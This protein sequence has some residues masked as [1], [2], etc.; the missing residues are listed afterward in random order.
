MDPLI[1]LL[2]RDH[3]V[4][5]S[6]DVRYDPR[7]ALDY[8]DPT[9]VQ[10]VAG[11]ATDELYG[12][13]D[14]YESLLEARE[15]YGKGA[16]YARVRLL[17]NPFEAISGA[18]FLNRAAT[19]IASI[20][21][22]FPS[23]I[24]DAPIVRIGMLAEAPGAMLEYLMWHVAQRGLTSEVTAISLE[25]GLKWA[26]GSSSLPGVDP[27]RL[28]I[29]RGADGTGDL[30][31][32]E[33]IDAYV[34]STL[35][36]GQRDLVVADGGVDVDEHPERQE[37][38]NAPLILGETLC[39]LQVLRVGGGLVLKIYDGYDRFTSDAL[40]LLCRHFRRSTIF[41]PLTSRPANAERY[42]VGL[43]FTG[44]HIEP[45]ALKD[46]YGVLTLAA[47]PREG[48]APGSFLAKAPSI[49]SDFIVRLNDWHGRRQV[50][51]LRWA[52]AVDRALTE[53]PLARPSYPIGYDLARFYELVGIPY[54]RSRVPL[55]L[56]ST[57]CHEIRLLD[58]VGQLARRVS[59]EDDALLD[60]LFDWLRYA[61]SS[62]AGS[63]GDDPLAP[64]PDVLDRWARAPGAPG[65]TDEATRARLR[66]LLLEAFDYEEVDCAS[67]SF[68]VAAHGDKRVIRGEDASH[69]VYET[70]QVARGVLA[71]FLT[72]R[73]RARKN[74]HALAELAE[75]PQHLERGF[76]FL[77]HYEALRL[78]SDAYSVVYPERPDHDLYATLLTRSAGAF[79]S[80]CASL[81]ASFGAIGLPLGDGET[82]PDPP[83]GALVSLNL[84]YASEPRLRSELVTRALRLVE[85]GLVRRV[86][87]ASASSLA[88][89]DKS[90]YKRGPPIIVPRDKV[91]NAITGK[92][93]DGRVLLYALEPRGEVPKSQ[94]EEAE[95]HRGEDDDE[96][97][98]ERFEVEVVAAEGSKKARGRG[99]SKPRSRG[100]HA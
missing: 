17:A 64:D 6:T 67:L 49:V 88:A 34:S 23:L 2:A 22:A 72:Q 57:A 45:R 59:A 48:A 24:P 68:R 29:L 75:R 39:A 44:L 83:R 77:K 26:I 43:G 30:L 79:H 73:E 69:V 46:L 7:Y 40:Q 18:A 13:L 3:V 54:V 9:P 27:R 78:T 28:T 86:Y 96:E 20:R 93:Y 33:N 74:A 55:E 4:S 81:E 92:A 62:G 21:A 35:Q 32:P 1:E 98:A 52:I 94:E 65:T 66:D 37:A 89:L 16:N 47:R 53:N 84:L 82:S 56:P 58:R 85:S 91:V 25:D 80:P 12:D 5:E 71:L 76:V 38:S 36:A 63:S 90:S 10:V 100:S 15:S 95:E 11:P 99:S 31:V 70:P 51:F 60:L 61:A 42:F 14:V 8:Y 97:E 87:V 41:K 19:K 50:S